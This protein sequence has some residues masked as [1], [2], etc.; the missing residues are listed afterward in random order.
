MNGDAVN[1]AKLFKA[2][3]STCHTINEGG[4]N[5]QGPNLYSVMGRKSGSVSGFKYTNANKNSGIIWDDGTMFEYLTNPKK[6]I[7]G[8]NM[9]F[10]GFK[11]EKDRL[12]VIAYLNKFK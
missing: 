6:F 9:A 11:K 5:K 10:P 4:P 7:K 12:D 2:K 3:C 8:T 1:G